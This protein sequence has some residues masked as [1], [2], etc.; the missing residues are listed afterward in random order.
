MCVPQ[1][2]CMPSHEHI[3]PQMY[4]FFFIHVYK[5]KVCVDTLLIIFF[6]FYEIR[7][8]KEV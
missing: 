8:E 6:T 4:L 1:L 7:M 5:K 2:Y 3:Y